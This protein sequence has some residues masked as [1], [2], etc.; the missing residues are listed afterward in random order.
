MAITDLIW[1]RVCAHVCACMHACVVCVHEHVCVNA[2]MSIC[3][4]A[5]CVSADACSCV[6]TYMFP[7]A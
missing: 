3:E 2:R 7:Y 1:L 5:V 4:Y 6:R